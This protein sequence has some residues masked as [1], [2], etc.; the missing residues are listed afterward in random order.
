MKPLPLLIHGSPLSNVAATD[1][2]VQRVIDLG[3]RL[4]LDLE[5]IYPLSSSPTTTPNRGNNGNDDNNMGLLFLIL[6]GGTEQSTLQHIQKA[7]SGGGAVGLVA[8]PEF[9][10]L[11]AAL[12]IAAYLQGQQQTNNNNGGGV[13]LVRL[14]KEALQ[15]GSKNTR[16]LAFTT[17]WVS[18]GPCKPD[19]N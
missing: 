1:K 12:E 18:C 9:N 15:C 13:K 7:Y 16:P 3:K 11:P 4:G 5:P 19:D 14:S 6:T 8:H 10:S 2:V 17:W